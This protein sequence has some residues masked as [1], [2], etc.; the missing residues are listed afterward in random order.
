M[1]HRFRFVSFLTVALVCALAL[2]AS[3]VAADG[4]QTVGICVV[5]V[6]SPCNGDHDE[7]ATDG[8]KDGGE[9]EPVNP[10]AFPTDPD[11]TDPVRPTD[12]EPD[13][14]EGPVEESINEFVDDVPLMQQSGVRGGD[15]PIPT[16]PDI[17]C[18]RAP[19][20]LPTAEPLPEKL[21]PAMDGDVGIEILVPADDHATAAVSGAGAPEHA[22]WYDFD[23]APSRFDLNPFHLFARLFGFFF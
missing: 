13:W 11:G 2:S 10:D 16:E 1:N 21:P 9:A 4:D 23:V 15:E 8:E 3:P 22:A 12:P 14:R 18:I 6:D 19:C 17:V 20:E 7:N 5:G